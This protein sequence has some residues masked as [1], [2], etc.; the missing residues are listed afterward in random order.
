MQATYINL[1][2]LGKIG[3]KGTNE[4]ALLLIFK[5]SF[6]GTYYQLIKFK[7]IILQKYTLVY[8]F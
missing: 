8:Q 5:K 1:T 6:Y 4:K 7:A 3:Q 2:F